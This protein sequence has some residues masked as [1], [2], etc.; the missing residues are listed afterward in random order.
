MTGLYTVVVVASASYE[1]LHQQ[2][3][4]DAEVDW[5]IDDVGDLDPRRRWPT[6]APARAVVQLPGHETDR[7]RDAASG[8]QADVAGI[9][10]VTRHDQFAGH[11]RPDDD[12]SS[13]GLTQ[14]SFVAPIEGLADTTFAARYRQHRAVVA[15][16]H[17]GVAHYR[18]DVIVDKIDCD[19]QLHD[20]RAV[21]QL[22]FSSRAHYRDQY[23][24]DADSAA[25][26]R[27]DIEH[28]LDPRRTWSVLTTTRRRLTHP[29]LVA[30]DESP[31]D[32]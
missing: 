29:S 25:V 1:E 30:G 31:I 28:F 12:D 32:G 9:L 14:I 18:Q 21:S 15:A 13:D 17:P 27:A 20:C 7:V 2:L 19:P 16:Q 24:A 10:H 5:A 11:W 23:Y 8:A 26:V 3:G 6:P 22:W 4:E